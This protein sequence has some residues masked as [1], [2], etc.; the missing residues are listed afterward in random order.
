[1]EPF[2]AAAPTS[3]QIVLV[4]SG[5][6]GFLFS[7]SAMAKAVGMQRPEVRPRRGDAEPVET[8]DE[9]LNRLAERPSA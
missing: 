1:V 6:L 3:M 7:L 2:V 9:V 8:T 4:I 5:G